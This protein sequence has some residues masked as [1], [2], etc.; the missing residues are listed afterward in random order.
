MRVSPRG[1]LG[2]P[3]Q[4]TSHETHMPRRSFFRYASS[5]AGLAVAF[6]SGCAVYRPL[7][8]PASPAPVPD[9]GLL[10]AQ[11]PQLRHAR[12]RPL[13][14]D[15]SGALRPEQLAVLAVIAN[16]DLKA[17]RARVGVADAQAFAAGLLPDP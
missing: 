14:I 4:A 6:L 8:L 16:P 10:A 11:G 12:L 1:Q 3:T 17:A 9:F 2:A 7:P 5:L 15:L 13:Q